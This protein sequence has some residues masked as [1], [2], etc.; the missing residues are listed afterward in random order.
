MSPKNNTSINNLTA[1][2]TQHTNPAP[3]KIDNVFNTKIELLEGL[4]PSR[5]TVYIFKTL[6]RYYIPII[7]QNFKKQAYRK[8]WRAKDKGSKQENTQKERMKKELE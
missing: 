3:I 7:N 8:K 1:K 2:T 5:N 6:L 4:P